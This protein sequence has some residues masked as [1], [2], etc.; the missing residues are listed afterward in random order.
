MKM[1]WQEE[2]GLGLGNNG[3][4]DECM[5]A[6]WPSFLT[7]LAMAVVVW[8][9]DDKSSGSDGCTT[10]PAVVATTMFK[11][12]SLGFGLQRFVITC[13]DHQAAE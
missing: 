13:N 3:W 1:K 2:E 10:S 11:L 9:I 8:V 7:S 4:M 5:H 6:L 12:T